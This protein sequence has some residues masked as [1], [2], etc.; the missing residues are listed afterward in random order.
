M[1]ALLNVLIALAA[2]A[3]AYTALA[4]FCIWICDRWEARQR[5]GIERRN[6]DAAENRHL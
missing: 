2:V 6:R 3:L 5:A 4:L 1:I